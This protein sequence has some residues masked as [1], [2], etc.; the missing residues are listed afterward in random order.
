MA[1]EI[2]CAQCDKPEW[3]CQCERYCG[4]CKSWDNVNLCTDGQYYCD[5]CRE[6]CEL[7]LANPSK[8]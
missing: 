8:H 3:Q 5:S 1:T 2:V 7:D 6:A 4:L